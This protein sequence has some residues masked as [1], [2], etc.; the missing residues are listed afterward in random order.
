MHNLECK[1][2][3]NLYFLWKWRTIGDKSQNG[4]ATEPLSKRYNILLLNYSRCLNILVNPEDFHTQTP[5]YFLQ[6]LQM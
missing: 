2:V 5:T 4:F 1:E 3:L 6:T